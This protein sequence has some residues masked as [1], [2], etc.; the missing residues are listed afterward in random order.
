MSII[1]IASY[2]KSGNTWVRA[3]LANLLSNSKDPV[4]INRLVYYCDFDY[5]GKHYATLAGRPLSELSNAQ[6]N[7]MRPDVQRQLARRSEDTVYCKTHSAAAMVS[8]VPA[9]ASGITKSAVYIVRNPL[10]VCISYAVFQG[11][12]TDQAVRHLCSN[13]AITERDDL[14]VCQFLGSWSD[15]VNSWLQAKNLKIHFVRYE[16]LV[17][18]PVPTFGELVRFLEIGGKHPRIETA[19]KFSQFKTLKMQEELFGFV[20]NSVQSERF[21]RAGR[22]GDWRESL[23]EAQVQRIIDCNG[24]AMKRFGYLDDRGRPC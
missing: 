20:E 10:D 22:R 7:T 12:D 14:Q 6:I 1:W 23:S 16:D 11:I 24:D 15:H 9:F 21:F 18:N 2:P 8:G 4:P 5:L 3:F 19:I 13:S 17:S